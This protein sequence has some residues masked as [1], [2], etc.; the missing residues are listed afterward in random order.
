[1]ETRLTELEQRV[2]GL[3]VLGEQRQADIAAEGQRLLDGVQAESTAVKAAIGR[4]VVEAKAEF[5]RQREQQEQTFVAAREEFEKEKREK[6]QQVIEAAAAEFKKQREQ[7][8][9]QRPDL[10]TLHQAMRIEIG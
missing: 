10:L 1:M 8:E 4:T 2:G 9:Q 7:Q 5:D 6:Q 3:R